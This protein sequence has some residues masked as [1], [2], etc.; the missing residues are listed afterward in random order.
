MPRVTMLAVRPAWWCSGGRSRTLTASPAEHALPRKA[1]GAILSQ[2]GRGGGAPISGGAASEALSLAPDSIGR[3]NHG[4]IFLF[5]CARTWA[6]DACGKAGEQEEALRLLDDMR[7]AGFP[8]DTVVYNSAIDACSVRGDWSTALRLLGEMKDGSAG[9]ASPDVVSYGGAITACA[10]AGRARQALQ[11]MAELRA[12]EARATEAAVRGRDRS[13][14]ARG[15][16]EE[17]GRSAV[18]SL[19]LPNLVTYS[20]TLFACLKAGEVHRGGEVLEEMI[21]AGFQPNTIHCD[22]LI[23]A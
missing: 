15:W 12:N 10:R 18:A 2:W 7:G 14:P 8:P 17:G 5:S 19:P 4:V 22:T 3:T 16:R 21:A 20:A 9:A 1:H 13:A 6:V 23:A 11:L